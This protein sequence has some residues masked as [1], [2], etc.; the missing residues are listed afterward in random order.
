[1]AVDAM[2]QICDFI[3]RISSV[4]GKIYVLKQ[5]AAPKTCLSND[6]VSICLATCKN[7]VSISSNTTSLY[8]NELWW[9]SLICKNLKEL[10]IWIL[11]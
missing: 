1:M 7:N 8:Q 5:T 11:I 10:D 3:K 6:Y 2:S 9:I 4:L